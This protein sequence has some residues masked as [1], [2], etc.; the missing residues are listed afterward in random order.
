M[1]FA[2]ECARLRRLYG[3]SPKSIPV[4][5]AG[6]LP[7]EQAPPPFTAIKGFVITGGLPPLPGAETIMPSPASPPSSSASPATRLAQP[8]RAN[9][10]KISPALVELVAEDAAREPADDPVE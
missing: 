3:R 10:A 1:S 4:H 7:G 9:V 8:E 6:G 5:V 2:S